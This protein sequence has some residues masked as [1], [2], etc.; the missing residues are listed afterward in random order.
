MTNASCSCTTTCSSLSIVASIIIGIITGFL[1]YTGAVCICPVFLWVLFAVSIVWLALLIITS[2][3]GSSKFKDCICQNVNRLIVGILGTIL[4]SVIL[5][6]ICF[7]HAWF[8]GAILKGLLLLFFSL[9]VT[10]TAC[11]IKCAADCDDE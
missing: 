6:T 8:I 4:V 2:A 5:L 3:R 11:V 10:S 9:T 1:A 7:C